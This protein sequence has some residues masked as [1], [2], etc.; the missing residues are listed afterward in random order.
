LKKINKIVSFLKMLL[1]KKTFSLR[2]LARGIG[3][4]VSTFLAV[5]YGK[6]HFRSLERLKITALQKA[7]GDFDA[8]VALDDASRDDLNWWIYKMPS[9]SFYC[10]QHQNALA[11][12]TTD[13][14]NL[15]WGAFVTEA[16]LNYLVEASR[17]NELRGVF[18]DCTILK[19]INFKELL[20]VKLALVHFVSERCW[21]HC[22][23]KIRSDNTTALV[24][25]RTLRIL[26]AL[27]RNL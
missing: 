14:S 1:D 3:L 2:E 11:V 24:H 6:L 10:F 5:P 17:F 15:F 20:A 4:V 19:S 8:K 12:I 7:S 16:K 9:V 23:I 13:A 26:V 22:T 27:N 21:T 25:W 18:D